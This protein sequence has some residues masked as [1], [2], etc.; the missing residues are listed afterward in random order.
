VRLNQ[1]WIELPESNRRAALKALS[2]LLARKLQRP[3]GR[4]EAADDQVS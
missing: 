3:A 1:L 2:Q 4:K